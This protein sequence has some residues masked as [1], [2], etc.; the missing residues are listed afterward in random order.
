MIGEVPKT[1]RCPHAK[2]KPIV[3]AGEGKT[4]TESIA[5]A[6]AMLGL[7]VAHY[8]NLLQCCD[9]DLM[10]PA[11]CTTNPRGANRTCN[12]ISWSVSAEY[13][14]LRK[15]LEHMTTRE[16]DDAGECVRARAR[17]RERER[18]REGLRPHEHARPSVPPCS[19]ASTAAHRSRP[20]A[21]RLLRLRRLRCF[22]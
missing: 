21:R 6:L 18:E 15:Q 2:R 13:V 4:G 3:I 20:R 7:K 10:P 19:H 12:G 17:A 9:L 16:Y 22:R 11:S 5:T 1:R 14:A 8:E